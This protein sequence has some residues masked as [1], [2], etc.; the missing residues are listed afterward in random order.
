[1][2]RGL[3]LNVW[4]DQ[5]PPDSPYRTREEDRDQPSVYDLADG[6]PV[7]EV[8]IWHG[9][10]S[11]WFCMSRQVDPRLAAAGVVYFY[12]IDQL[13]AWIAYLDRDQPT[14]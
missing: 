14:A 1:M 8:W 4:D 6:S 7:F 10:L 5:L 3:I 13:K 12:G 2:K 9:R 11:R